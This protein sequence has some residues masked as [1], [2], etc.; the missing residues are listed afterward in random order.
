MRNPTG[1]W[2][3]RP[4]GGMRVEGVAVFEECGVAFGLSGGMGIEWVDR[5]ERRGKCCA[6]SDDLCQGGSFLEQIYPL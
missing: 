3:Q 5:F 6:D 4:P 2:V 1:V